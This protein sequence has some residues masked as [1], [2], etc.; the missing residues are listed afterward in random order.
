MKPSLTVAE[1]VELF[2][3]RGLVITDQEE[4]SRFLRSTSYYRFSGYFRYFQRAPHLGDNTFDPT[5]TFEAIPA[6]YDAD[7]KLRATL[8]RSLAHAEL[9]LRTHVARVIA[10]KH[11]GYGNYLDRDFYSDLGD[12]EPTVESCLRDIERSRE[13]HILRYRT[14]GIEI[15]LY[16]DLPVWSAVEAWSFGTLSKVIER[17][18]QGSLGRAV[19]SSIGVAQAGFAYRVKALVYLRNRCAHHSRLWNHS[20]IDAGP[21]PNNVRSKG[22]RVAGQFSPRSVLDVVASLGDILIRGNA[23]PP[24]LDDL[25]IQHG[26][27]EEFWNGLRQPV[28]PQDHQE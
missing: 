23:T 18:D 3:K 5:V 25:V 4:C 2:A 10:D 21:T 24:I 27:H 13:R 26:A 7:E 12:A 14:P 1:Q 9:L 6:I 11:G 8:T 20:V 22:K 15:P 19:A 17:G 28:A 16:A